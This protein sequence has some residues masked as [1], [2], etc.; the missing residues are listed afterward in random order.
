MQ[1]RHDGFRHEP[2]AEVT[3]AS[4]LIRHVDSS[5]FV[6]A[7]SGNDLPQ[8]QIAAVGSD[9]GGLDQT[10]ADQNAMDPGLL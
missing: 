8:G 5:L 3:K 6:V 1:R 2:A 9:I 7:N 4:F 10:F